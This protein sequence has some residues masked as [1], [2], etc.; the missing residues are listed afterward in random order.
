MP[1][2]TIPAPLHERLDATFTPAAA[3]EPAS[4]GM[5]SPMGQDSPAAL[6]VRGGP[7]AST[8]IGQHAACSKQHLGRPR[9]MARPARPPTGAAP[10]ARMQHPAQRGRG[11]GR[12]SAA[13][14]AGRQRGR[15]RWR[16]HGRRGAFTGACAPP[17]AHHA[18]FAPGS[19]PLTL[20]TMCT[21]EHSRGTCARV[22]AT[23]ARPF[24]AAA[25]AQLLSV[26]DANDC[27]PLHLAILNGRS[28]ALCCQWG[29]HSS[30]PCAARLCRCM[31]TQPAAHCARHAPALARHAPARCVPGR[32]C[33]RTAPRPPLALAIAVGW[34]AACTPT[35][36]A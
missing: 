33:T 3:P 6:C 5:G 34:E 14:A 36:R 27:T 8:R 20:A 32:A 24:D 7:R 9:P 11:R 4:R 29:R 23:Q 26:A 25:L 30:G 17:R 28:R 10:L 16:E 12:R 18:A 2:R 1:N 13:P 21:M 31:H 15:G 35:P 22:R 19:R